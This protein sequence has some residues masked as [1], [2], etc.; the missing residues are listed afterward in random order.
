MRLSAAAVALLL[1]AGAPVPALSENSG[2]EKDDLHPID[3]TMEACIDADSSTAGMVTCTLAAEQAWDED[4]NEAY[5]ELMAT[6]DDEGKSRL[7][8]AQ[9][10]WIAQRDSEFSFQSWMRGE[11]D[12]TMWGPVIAGQRMSFVRAR[13]LQLRSYR[14]TLDSGR[15]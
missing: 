9:R 6:L 13:A 1:V 2:A 4:L 15:P 8:S 11:L 3:R 10:A 5:G 7:R 14:E 12:G